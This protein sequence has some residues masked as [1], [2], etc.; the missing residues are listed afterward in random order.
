M[1][2]TACAPVSVLSFDAPRKGIF[3]KSEVPTDVQSIGWVLGRPAT[4]PPAN[5][6]FGTQLAAELPRL[7]RKALSLCKNAS[8]ADDLIQETALRALRF[9]STFREDSNL[10]A[11]TSR[12]LCSVFLSWCR[13]R[14]KQRVAL[15]RLGSDPNAWTAVSVGAPDLTEL[16]PRLAQVVEE[17]PECFSRVL[18]LVDIEEFS[19]AEA[20]QTLGVPVGTIMSR[21]HR[22]RK[23]LRERLASVEICPVLHDAA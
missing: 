14:T 7:R 12:I 4:P 23:R 22:G 10:K 17:L 13:K 9:Q 8:L 20:A 5:D 3:P 18:R 11:W 6:G 19:Y 16:P 21:L 2:T 15:E 1:P